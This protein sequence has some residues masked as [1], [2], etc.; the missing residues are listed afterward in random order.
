MINRTIVYGSP[1]AYYR[2]VSQRHIFYRWIQEPVVFEYNDGYWDIDNYPYYVYHGYRYRYSPVEMCKYDLVD[3][4][5]YT[6]V[7]T[8]EQACTGGYDA[9]AIERD[10]MNHTI[11]MERYFCAEAVDEE[12]EQSNASTYQS[13]P[14]TIG[15]VKRAAIVAFLEGKTFKDL[16]KAGKAKKAGKCVIKKQ[17]WLLDP[18]N[19]FGCKYVVKVSDKA[20][21]LVDGSVCSEDTQAALVGCNVGT[22]KENAGC[23][24]QQAVQA[25][26]CL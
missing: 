23:I 22:E 20:F 24:L 19:D 5:D 21:P 10:T 14:V 3:G 25:G 18:Q 11:G 13:T 7:R 9:C 17:G 16:F 6:T 1:R 4:N 15:D 12:F 8:Y 2:H 26:Y